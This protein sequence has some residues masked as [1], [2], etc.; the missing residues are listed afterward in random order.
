MAQCRSGTRFAREALARIW[1]VEVAGEHFD[2]D[3]STEHGIVCDIHGAHAAATQSPLN[4]VPADLRTWF[5]HPR[6]LF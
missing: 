4:F 1:H 3:H 2:R 5:Q 6:K